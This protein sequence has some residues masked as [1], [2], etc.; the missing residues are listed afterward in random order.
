MM[1]GIALTLIT[2]GCAI[3]NFV[4]GAPSSR[5]M[6]PAHALLERRCR[7]CH[8]VPEPSSMS[9][10]AWQAAL[11]RMKR[12]MQLPASEWVSLAAMP[13]HDVHHCS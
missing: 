6:T 2:T 10:G 9:T 12:R 1:V 13:V 3:G 11:E 7:G 8:V 5:S 4:T